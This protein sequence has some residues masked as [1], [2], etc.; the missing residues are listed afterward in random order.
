MLELVVT[1]LKQMLKIKITY[2]LLFALAALTTVSAQNNGQYVNDSNYKKSLAI[3]IKKSRRLSVDSD[4][5]P[6][7]ITE[8]KALHARYHD[9]RSLVYITF[10]TAQ[11]EWMA[12]NHLRSMELAIKS[13][14][15]AHKGMVTELLPEIYSLIGALHK[16]NTN[17]PM[18]F[19]AAENGV[20]AAKRNKD[21]AMIIGLL[22]DKAMYKRSYSLHYNKPLDKD[23]SLEIRLEALK[24]AE[25]NP[26]YERARIPFYDN[27]AQ[28]YKDFKK[29]EKAKYYAN[30]GI[31]LALKYDQKRSL[32]YGYNWLGEAYYFDGDKKSGMMYLN[33][34]LEL[35]IMLKQPFRKM[36]L[37]EAISNC[38]ESSGNY[39]E[40]LFYLNKY[41]WLHDSLQVQKNVKNIG[42]LQ[43]K[44]ET[45][46][47]DKS[48]ALLNQANLVREK[49][50][51]WLITGSCLFIIVL[52]IIL[53][54]YGVIRKKNRILTTNNHKINEQAD[55][56]QTLM[57]EL[58]HRVKNNLQIVSSLLGLQSS[59][60]AD[61]EAR[62]A[63][64]LSR[65]R[66]EAMS[67][68]HN[69]L[70]QQ[71]STNQVNMNEFLPMLLNN[72]I[73]SFGIKRDDIDLDM[74]I[75]INDMDV[76][77]AMPLGLIMNEWITN[78]FKHAYQHIK[79]R[80]V[81]GIF[82]FYDDH[83]IKLRVK[84]NG[85]G[86]PLE[87]WESPKGSFGVKLMMVLIK[88]IN[89]VAHVSNEEGTLLKLDV[90]YEK[91]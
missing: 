71:G 42:E 23:S 36:E 74:E 43:I 84:D 73:E 80:P 41:R 54:M 68:I 48:L 66:I 40:A 86:M 33:K 25:A 51:K 57:Q 7:V 83:K 69:S 91:K 20:E 31:N 18:A 32:T 11:I 4:S 19:I 21:T 67:I 6:G 2:L 3:L 50:L 37:Y 14:N 55:K 47:K 39:K 65:Q 44:Y 63:I 26:K 70:Y 5:L 85:I 1:L 49:K 72:I 90:P 8:F 89:A 60:M 62:D 79:K 58:H 9:N 59:R 34:A 30:K 82:V 28:H 46:K 61:S 52:I 75:L 45:A 29:Y 81:I 27:I 15:E 16:E 17:Y 24:I 38:Y 76:D 77:I 12:A 88:Q 87:L 10:N 64:N 78:I 35:T 56:L 13:L 22:G 53:Y